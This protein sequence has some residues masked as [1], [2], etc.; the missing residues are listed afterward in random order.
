MKIFIL[1]K[2][3]KIFNIVNLKDS[4]NLISFISINKLPKRLGGSLKNRVSKYLDLR[5]R[6]Y[7]IINTK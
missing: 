3:S 7:L 4:S 2:N 5:K 1:N 6:G